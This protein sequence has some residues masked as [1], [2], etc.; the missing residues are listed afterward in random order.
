MLAETYCYREVV[1]S[2]LSVL[3]EHAG[4]GV[5]SRAVSEAFHHLDFNN[6]EIIRRWI[7]MKFPLITFIFYLLLLDIYIALTH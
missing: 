4:C 3:E 1:N 2:L 5:E 7:L 6:S